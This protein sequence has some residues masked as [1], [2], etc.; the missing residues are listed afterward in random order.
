MKKEYSGK[1]VLLVLLLGAAG[2]GAALYPYMKKSSQIHFQVT[3]QMQ[4]EVAPLL[5][6]KFLLN[7]S[8]QGSFKWNDLKPEMPV[9]D[10]KRIKYRVRMPVNGLNE[11]NFKKEVATQVFNIIKEKFNDLKSS[12]LTIEVLPVITE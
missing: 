5:E 9:I 6:E 10:G 8:E 2:M 7:L 3:T 12:E 11:A 1:W 4:Q